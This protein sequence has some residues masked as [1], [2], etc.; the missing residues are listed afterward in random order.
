VGKFALLIGVSEFAEEDLPRLPSALKDIQAM[1][2]ILQ[3]PELSEF[4]SVEL[5][6]NPSRQKMEESIEI[7]F[8]NRK[9]DDLLLFY[10]S[11]HGVTDEKGRLYLVTPETRKDRGNLRKS[12]G[13]AATVLHQHMQDS[14]SKHQVLILDSCFSGAFAEG[15]TG[16]S[17]SKIDIQRELG[18]EGRA[19]LTSSNAVQQSFHVEGYDLSIYTHYLV[20]GIQ[21]GDANQ[22]GDDYISV[23][24]L[25]EYVKNR[26]ERETRL[27]NPQFFPVREGYKIKLVRS[28]EVKETS[29]TKYR[30]EAEERFY[31]GAFSPIARRQLN[32]KRDNLG[33]SETQAEAIEAEVQKP[34]KEEQKR[35]KK[36][37]EYKEDILKYEKAFL[38]ELK[39]QIPLS[40]QTLF[41]LDEYRQEL[42]L[43]PKEVESVYRK[44]KISIFQ[45]ESVSEAISSGLLTVDGSPSEAKLLPK[46]GVDYTELN[47]YLAV[48]DWKAADQATN[49][50]MIQAAKREKEGYLTYNDVKYFPYEDLQIIDNLWVNY[51]KGKWGFSVQVSIWRECGS[52][53]ISHGDDWRKFGALVGW[54]IPNYPNSQYYYSSQYGG[55]WIDSSEDLIFDLD[56]SPIG[57]LPFGGFC[58]WSTD[59]DSAYWFDGG[60]FLLPEVFSEKFASH[61]TK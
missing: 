43:H 11:G 12:T 1:Q 47:H 39:R 24:E 42:G 50:L 31:Q 15:L 8:A 58:S 36:L 5:L 55:S 40:N 35:L 60:W 46:T 45:L 57:E 34:W 29:E 20:E 16:K 28:P 53:H 30:K 59:D 33:L 48:G 14:N 38:E 22:D 41:K 2:A 56:K 52:P 18:G 23:D 49:R 51:S 3:N 37:Q 61:S 17:P 7:L 4:S 6:A 21:T 32:H 26:V 27:M 10:F 54:Y 25:H 19:I 13:V 44:L 9:K